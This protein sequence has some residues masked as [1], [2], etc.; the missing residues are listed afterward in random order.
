MMV[1][2]T[3]AEELLYFKMLVSP[4]RLVFDMISG[5]L[6]EF[7]MLNNNQTTAILIIDII[8]N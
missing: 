4:S 5:L 6:R 7:T 3:V 8:I 1:C 2:L